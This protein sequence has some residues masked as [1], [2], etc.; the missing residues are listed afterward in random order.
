MRG[1]PLR[2]VVAGWAAL[3]ACSPANDR[4]EAEAALSALD[5]QVAGTDRNL[6]DTEAVAAATTKRWKR[7][8]AAFD[9]AL[10]LAQQAE[11]LSK[12]T[13][14]AAGGAKDKFAE[15]ADAFEKAG[16]DWERTKLLLLLAASMDLHKE[17][18]KDPVRSKVRSA[19]CEPVSTRAQRRAYEKQGIS[20]AGKDVDHIVPRSLG[21]ADH[22]SNYMPLDASTNRSIGNMFG[23]AKC[24]MPGVGQAKCALAIAI[25]RK[26]G[27][28]K[29]RMP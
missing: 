9:K 7:V 27:T 13:L 2:L 29:G 20:L 12:E 5:R 3:V 1:V 17:M 24:A 6:T 23:K 14:L 22:P 10:G 18:S 8:E 4:A 16:I 11:G 26:C 15:A 25:S 28:F 21:G 19:S